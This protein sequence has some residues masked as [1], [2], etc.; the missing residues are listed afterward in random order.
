MY[1]FAA[2]DTRGIARLSDSSRHLREGIIIMC[3]A[4]IVAAFKWR[5]NSFDA[6]V[7]KNDRQVD[8]D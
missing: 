8:F 2:Q 6:V 5:K 3:D 1:L 7:L 4:C